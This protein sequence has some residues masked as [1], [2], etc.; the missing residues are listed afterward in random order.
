VIIANTIRL[1]EGPD[2]IL[3]ADYQATRVPVPEGVKVSGT[4]VLTE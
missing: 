3:N 4:V 2:M 1:N